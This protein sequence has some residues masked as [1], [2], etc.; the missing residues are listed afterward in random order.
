MRKVYGRINGFN[1][2]RLSLFNGLRLCGRFSNKVNVGKGSNGISGSGEKVIVPAMNS[3]VSST[4]DGT[5]EIISLNLRLPNNTKSTFNL[6]D[7]KTLHDLEETI[8]S[9]KSIE[10]IEFRSWDN[11]I[12]SKS[13]SLRNTLINN[14][15]PVFLRIDKLEWQEIKGSNTSANLKD[16]TNKLNIPL[17]EE[18]DIK[19]Q[20]IRNYYNNSLD[21]KLMSDLGFSNYAQ[22]FEALYQLKMD[23]NKTNSEY[24]HDERKAQ[25]LTLILLSIGGLIFIIELGLLYWGTFIEYSWDITEPITYLVL[26][27]NILLALLMKKKFKG[28]PSHQYFT[29]RFLQ[30]KKSTISKKNLQSKLSV[31][32]NKL[33]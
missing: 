13:S 28:I 14:T 11:S 5:S 6:Q 33:I 25:R 8:K 23:F 31:L 3:N 16:S 4:V 24:L 20:Q 9:N 27:G 12:I 1:F 26:C 18:Q 32:E 7:N 30:S 2:S 29:Q 21:Q 15:D 17:N 22:Y 19:I 10:R